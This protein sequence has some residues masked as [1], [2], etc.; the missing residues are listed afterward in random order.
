MN[1]DFINLTYIIWFLIAM[2]IAQ[3]F[4][5]GFLI[6]AFN[7]VGVG[8]AWGVGYLFSPVMAQ[9]IAKSNFYDFTLNFTN[10]T[11]KLQA[12]SNLSVSSLTT[13]QIHEIVTKADLPSPYS[14]LFLDNM[15]HGAFES[16]GLHTVTE[17]L[18][19]TVANVTVNILSFL[20]IYILTRLMIS[21]LVNA[22]NYA[23]ALPVLRHCDGLAGGGLGALRGAFEMFAFFMV[24]PIILIALPEDFV[25]PFIDQS[26]IAAY[27]F[28]H[29]FLLNWIS[30]VI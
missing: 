29:N 6:S 28:E 20:L 4:Y 5:R 26:K 17:Y 21:L 19:H 12:A 11:E 14:S 7:T 3:G 8:V 16:Q 1:L 18:N 9:A 24:V 23:S 25:M 15:A 10:T 2:Y 13:Q 22:V 30:G 27:F